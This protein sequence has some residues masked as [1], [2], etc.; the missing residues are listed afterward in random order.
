MNRGT[1]H[2]MTVVTRARELV[3]AGWSYDAAA[4]LL[5]NEGI[6]VAAR[7]ISRWCDPARQEADRRRNLEYHRAHSAQDATYR[8]KGSTPEYRAGFIRLL[9]GHGMLR[10]QIA[11]ACTVVFGVTVSRDDVVA[12]LDEDRVPRALRCEAS[13]A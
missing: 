7:T 6:T 8:L 9:A 1:G 4:R 2:P 5:A 13:R 11:I 3:D 10:T 12:V